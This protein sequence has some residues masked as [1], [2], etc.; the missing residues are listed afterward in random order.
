MPTFTPW[1]GLAL[2][3]LL[4]ASGCGQDAPPPAP[5]APSPEVEPPSGLEPPASTGPIDLLHATSAR[6]IVSSTFQDVASWAGRLVDSDPETA[7]NTRTGELED[8]WIAVYVPPEAHVASIALTAGFT[9]DQGAVDLFTG[10][11]RLRRVRVEHDSRSQTFTLD[12]ESRALQPLSLDTDGGWFLVDVVELLAGTHAEWREVCVS[13]LR[14][15]GTLEGATPGAYTPSVEIG[16]TAELPFTLPATAPPLR[17]TR[18]FQLL[19]ASCLE[20]PTRCLQSHDLP[21]IAA[22]GSRIAA[23]RRGQTM[24]FAAA[25][26]EADT[27]ALTL[28]DPRDGTVQ[29]TLPLI[30]G[31][32]PGAFLS[33]LTD[34]C[35]DDEESCD[36]ALCAP[37]ARASRALDAELHDRFAARIGATAPVL[38]DEDAWRPMVALTDVTASLHEDEARGTVRVSMDGRE[39]FT[40]TYSVCPECT[41][42]EASAWHDPTTRTLLVY[43]RA[44]SVDLSEEEARWA[45]TRLDP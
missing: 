13:E 30:D 26:Y 37:D 4:L 22:D 25:A 14:V 31:G 5:P 17:R 44:S 1:R 2:A 21:A 9:H 42:V 34:C 41:E 36:E 3:L 45:A 19:T 29:R 18:F 39:R 28:L 33:A 11:H 27:W 24:V 7:W 16:A 10:N 43:W 20:S 8:A 12:P 15:L 35:D 40:R 6:V 23:L 38:G 32:D